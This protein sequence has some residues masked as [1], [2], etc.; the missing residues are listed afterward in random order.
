MQESN[1]EDYVERDSPSVENV[2]QKIHTLEKLLSFLDLNKAPTPW[3]LF[4]LQC[5]CVFLLFLFFNCF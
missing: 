3:V 4:R 5:V 2:V 1:Q